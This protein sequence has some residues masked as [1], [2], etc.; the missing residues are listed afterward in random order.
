MGSRD[1]HPMTRWLAGA[2]D[3]MAVRWLL[4]LLLV[5]A[6]TAAATTEAAIPA[7]ERQALIDLY[8]STNGAGWTNSSDWNEPVGTE[9][10][11]S[12]VTCN[13]GQTTVL[14]LT[15]YANNLAGTL[16]ASLANL[17]DLTYLG[18]QV[19]KLSGSIPAQLANLTNL[20]YLD[21]HSN[22]L[23]VPLPTQL[24]NLTKLWYLDL[25]QNKLSGSIPTVLG[26]LT[27]LQYLQLSWNQ[28][29]GSIPTV[30][31]NLTNLQVLRLDSNQLVGPV[32]SSITNL[33]NLAAGSSDFRR[34]GVY[35]ADPAVVTFLNAA[36]FGGD[37]Q[38]TQTVAV[39]GLATGVT[40]TSSVVLTWTPIA[41]TSDPG[42]YQVFAS[43]ISGGPY[44]YADTIPDKSISNWTVKS[45]EPGTTYYFVMTSFTYKCSNNQNNV[46]SDRSA[47]VHATTTG[48]APNPLVITTPSPLPAGTVGVAYS[49]QLAASGGTSPYYW[50]PGSG[51]LPNGLSVCA[52]G[53]LNS[54]CGTP[55]VAGDF[56][57]TLVVYDNANTRAEGAFTLHVNA[58]GCTSP[59]I[60][61]QSQSQTSASGQTA[62]LSVTA[63]G[64]TPLSYQWYQGVS[65]DTS[66]PVG[67]NVSSFTTPVL[68][69]ATSYWVRVSNSCGHADS[70]TVTV[71]VRMPYGVRRHLQRQGP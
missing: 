31:G 1:T 16:P 40:N 4:A 11:W 23:L 47:E 58:S 42:G 26:N 55:T 19:N 52:N 35:S 61:S 57:F 17:T 21:L 29:S 60:T 9:C 39:M 66:H 59:S 68:T 2:I 63:A 18:L 67:T 33:T 24:G 64:T 46:T 65:G 36:Q 53:L 5:L 12:G 32:P 28:L 69:A 41:Y 30:L 51:S 37:W 70:A 62:T 49:Q 50:Y 8:T 45:L 6:V 34:N 43:G 71:T 22:Q 56:S 54:I 7:S 27:S 13:G 48:T 14:R 10:A 38:S 3:R 15:L 44:L 25:S 20:Q